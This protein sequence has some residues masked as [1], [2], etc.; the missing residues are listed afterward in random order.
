MADTKPTAPATP[1]LDWDAA[2]KHFKAVQEKVFSFL[3]KPGH[4]PYL[5]WN[6]TTSGA[7]DTGAKLEKAIESGNRSAE[8]H[9]AVLAYQ[10]APPTVDN[11]T[12]KIGIVPSETPA[13]G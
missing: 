11:D 5:H 7:L 1:T 12:V 10:F 2:L 8:L 3:G 9:K 4:N 6:K 13:K